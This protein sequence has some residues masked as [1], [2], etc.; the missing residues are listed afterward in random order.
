MVP[1]RNQGFAFIPSF[2]VIIEVIFVLPKIV[3]TLEWTL[4]LARVKLQI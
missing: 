4:D 2:R 1:L 3:S